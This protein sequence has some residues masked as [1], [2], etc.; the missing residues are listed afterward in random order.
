[1]GFP[2]DLTRYYQGAVNLVGRSG[3]NVAD[4]D[5]KTGY[6]VGIDILHHKTHEGEL[7]ISCDYQTSANPTYWL[8]INP[9]TTEEYHSD[10]TLASDVAGLLEIFKSPNVG[11]FNKGTQYYGYNTNDKVGGTSTL[12]KYAVPAGLTG[13]GTKIFQ[14]RIGAGGPQKVGGVDRGYTEFILANNGTYLWRFTPDA[15]A[16]FTL[17]NVLYSI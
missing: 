9:G 15:S 14:R 5:E 10:F 11:T 6:L 4:L 16:K 1:M 12:L 13:T 17:Q 8:V 7:F 3:T 2:F